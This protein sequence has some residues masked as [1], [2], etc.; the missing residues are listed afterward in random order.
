METMARVDSYMH[1]NEKIDLLL[2][3]GTSAAVYPAAGYIAKARAQGAKVAVINT[4]EPDQ[5][6]S[7]L[8]PGDWFFRG[9]AGAVVPQILESATGSVS[10]SP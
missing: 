4:E 7:R 8:E 9:D 5:A 2:V 1:K 3:I 10:T 6:A